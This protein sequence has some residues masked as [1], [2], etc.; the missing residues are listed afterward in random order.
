MYFWRTGKAGWDSVR[1]HYFC[2]NF[3]DS[4]VCLYW[5]SSPGKTIKRAFNK[6]ATLSETNRVPEN[7]WLEV[8]NFLFGEFRPIFRGELFVLRGMI[9]FIVISILWLLRTP[10]ATKKSSKH[11]LHHI[12]AWFTLAI[13]WWVGDTH[14]DDMSLQ[15]GDDTKVNLKNHTFSN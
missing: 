1:N 7:Q 10:S 3:R 4:Y 15:I 11:L 2:A 12:Q 14:P 13:C 8:W 5:I 9:I 6:S